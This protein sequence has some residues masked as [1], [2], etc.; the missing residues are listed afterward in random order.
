MR[1]WSG[2]RLLPT[3]R[4]APGPHG[5]GG[6]GGDSS[7]PMSVPEALLLFDDILARRREKEGLE[8]QP[9]PLLK[10]RAGYFGGGPA[11]GAQ[12]P[13]A[14]AARGAGHGSQ[15]REALCSPPAA[16]RG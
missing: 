2:Q 8:W 11:A 12:S 6:D 15:V 10:A 13:P 16:G 3:D 4:R 7:R 5:A 14:A 9:N 1:C